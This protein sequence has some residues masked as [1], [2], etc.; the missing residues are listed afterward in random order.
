MWNNEKGSS[1][2][3]VLLIIV[4]FT[5][6]GISLLGLNL[7]SAKQGS[8]TGNDIQATNLAEMGANHIKQIAIQTLQTN[9]DKS[10]LDVKLILQNNLNAA[11]LNKSF[12]IKN[13]LDFPN[14][15]VISEDVSVEDIA[16]EQA[17]KVIINFTTE[18]FSENQQSKSI[19]GVIQFTR[20]KGDAFPNAPE[21]S[22][23]YDETQVFDHNNDGEYDKT[24]YFKN[25]FVMNSNSKLTFDV[26]LYVNGTITQEANTDVWVKGDAYVKELDLKTNDNNNGNLALMCVDKTLFIY[27]TVQIPVET[28]FTN[29]EDVLAKK[30]KN[31]V[32]AKKVVYVSPTN[33]PSWGTENL[34]IDTQYK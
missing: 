34:T 11:L 17:Q 29:C 32:F 8:K 9:N 10:L 19:T 21:N 33:S 6:I 5:I 7:N 4:V 23:R 1:L 26:D 31:G 27:S 3:T 30:P 28:N 16:K 15:K 12:P 14:Y 18:G 25:G 24:L 20:G 2:L 22:T 13:N